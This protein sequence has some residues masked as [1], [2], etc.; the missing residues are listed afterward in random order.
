M[1]AV[2]GKKVFI[3]NDKNFYFI[4][5]VEFQLFS[6]NK[7]IKLTEEII[8][9]NVKNKLTEISEYLKNPD[10]P[11]Y[12]EHEMLTHTHS[13]YYNSL[14]IS[15]YSF[16]ERKLFMLSKLAENQKNIKVK[17]IRGEGIFK[18]YKYLKKVLEIDLEHLNNEWVVICRYNKL[19]NTLVHY[20]IN[21]IP[22]DNNSKLISQFKQIEFLEIKDKGEFITFEIND[23]RLLSKFIKV[24]H[25]F[26]REIYYE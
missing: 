3:D 13:L 7:Y 9:E 26:L 20:P 6:F 24:I 14:F 16:L 25:K 17:G 22:K 21:E 8:E 1:G 19:R 18:Y 2:R 15:L 5:D 12:G 4:V 10:Y 23:V 11:D